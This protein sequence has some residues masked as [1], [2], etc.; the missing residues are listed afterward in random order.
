MLITLSEEQGKGHRAAKQL[1]SAQRVQGSHWAVQ[2]WSLCPGGAGQTWV[3]WAEPRLQIMALERMHTEERS[4]SGPSPRTP[5]LETRMQ[6]ERGRAGPQEG[7]VPTDTLRWGGG[8]LCGAPG[9]PSKTREV[10]DHSVLIRTASLEER[11]QSPKW[12]RRWAVTPGLGL[13]CSGRQ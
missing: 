2:S 3:G 6:R 7:S 9:L 1:F 11:G 12:D 8:Q 10:R 13:P 5:R 4:G